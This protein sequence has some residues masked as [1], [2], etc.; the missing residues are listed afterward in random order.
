MM[1]LGTWSLL[2]IGLG[3]L[4]TGC[5]PQSPDTDPPVFLRKKGEKVEH[6]TVRMHHPSFGQGEVRDVML[7][8]RIDRSGFPVEYG[9]W[10]NSVFCIDN[11]C[12]VVTVKMYW[13]ALGRF[14]RYELPPG[15]QLTKSDHV[16]FTRDDYDKLQTILQDQGSILR[17]HSLDSLTRPVKTTKKNAESKLVDAVVQATEMT[18]KA[19]VVQGATYTSYNLWQWANG[20]IVGAI[21]EWTHQKCS[22]ALFL[23]FL[24]GGQSHEILFAIEHL[25]QHR[26][27]DRDALAAVMEVMRDG[28]NDRMEAGL[29]Y[30]RTAF[31]APVAYYEHLGLLFGN[32][33]RPA[34]IYLLNLLAVEE[35]LPDVLYESL[36][37]QIPRFGEY[38]E[39][40]LLLNLLE[41][42]HYVSKQVLTNAAAVLDNENFFMARRAFWFLQKQEL[43][44]DLQQKVKTFQEKHADRL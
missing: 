28:E 10:V 16:P 29:A 41:S 6:R 31:P 17:T 37:A 4:L 8:R 40:H 33:K 23:H 7:S 38:Y 20:E 25:G 5:T 36:V 34:Q 2:T 11:Q 44:A 9:M 15:T 43:P 3:L 35:K 39:L 13:D 1:R 14:A 24:K 42:R 18:V 12:E 30:L 19:A 32:S 26:I 21:R 27:F 22:K